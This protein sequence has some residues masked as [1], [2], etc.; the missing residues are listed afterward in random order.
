MKQLE[1]LLGMCGESHINL[2]HL[3]IVAV[4]ISIAY[5]QYKKR[6]V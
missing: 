2:Y 5:V 3:F 1:H 4:C 6:R